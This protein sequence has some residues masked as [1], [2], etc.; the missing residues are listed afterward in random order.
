MELLAGNVASAVVD[1][2]RSVELERRGGADNC[3]LV[4][5]LVNLGSGL[6]FAGRYP[7]GVVALKEARRACEAAGEQWLFS[8]TTTLLGL[9]AF[10]EGRIGDAASLAKG[11][12]ESKRDLGDLIGIGWSIELL[13]WTALVDGKAE[14]AAQLLGANRAL[15]EPLGRYLSTLPQ[16]V[17]L[18]ESHLARTQD[19]LGEVAFAAAE[20]LGTAL[21]RSEAVALALEESAASA[22][23]REGLED[24]PLTKREREIA[25]LVAAGMTNKSIAAQLVIGNRTVDTHVEHILSKLQFSSRSQIAALVGALKTGSRAT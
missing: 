20:H 22:G 23:S 4:N 17:E 14:R 24:L 25:A 16:L 1:L 15:S 10:T 13:A 6:C 5:A 9:A 3:H 8:W 12:L 18:H 19:A 21:S 11:A 2:E 7:D